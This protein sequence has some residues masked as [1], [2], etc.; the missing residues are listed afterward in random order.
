M[1]KIALYLNKFLII[2]N[3]QKDSSYESNLIFFFFL[4]VNIHHRFIISAIYSNCMPF[5]Y[6]FIVTNSNL[7]KTS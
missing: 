2:L 3:V 7:E 5:M 6:F 1:N 4:R